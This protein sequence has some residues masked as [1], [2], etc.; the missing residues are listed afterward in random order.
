[1][2]SSQQLSS[3]THIADVMPSLSADSDTHALARR[4]NGLDLSQLVAFVLLPRFVTVFLYEREMSW[5][6]TTSCRTADFMM[7]RAVNTRSVFVG[8]LLNVPVDTVE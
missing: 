6:L 5:L 8:W 3:V 1:M 4:S 7:L 2:D